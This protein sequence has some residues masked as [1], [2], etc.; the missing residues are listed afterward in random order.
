MADRSY[1][2]FEKS[3]SQLIASPTFGY[4]VIFVIAFVETSPLV[5]WLKEI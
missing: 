5:T 1:L 2:I 4:S 3:T